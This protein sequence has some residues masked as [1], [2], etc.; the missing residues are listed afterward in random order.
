MVTVFVEPF[1]L[2]RCVVFKIFHESC[3]SAVALARLR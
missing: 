3:Q 1:V 2:T